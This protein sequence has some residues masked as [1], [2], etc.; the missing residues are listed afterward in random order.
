MYQNA[1]DGYQATID[2]WNVS[3]KNWRIFSASRRNIKRRWIT[4]D[5]KGD[6]V[7]HFSFFG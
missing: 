3:R 6:K 1:V 5:K 2:I 4:Q 7:R